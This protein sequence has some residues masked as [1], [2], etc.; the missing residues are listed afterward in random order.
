M[1][2][3]EISGATASKD[4]DFLVSGP[5]IE[6]SPTLAI[7]S[8]NFYAKDEDE[9]PL[10]IA[11]YRPGEEI[12]ARFYIVGFRHDKTAIDVT[13]GVSLTDSSGQVMFQDPA[14]AR[15]NSTE[16]YPKPYVP[17]AMTFTLKPGTPTGEFAI[18][19]TARDA[20]GNQQAEARKSFRLE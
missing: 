3:S 19:I 20:V 1:F 2:V 9:K 4:L 16:F 11:A 17:G 7:R 12:H 14:A 8:L 15:D 13:Y 5:K 10:E 6:S 18:T